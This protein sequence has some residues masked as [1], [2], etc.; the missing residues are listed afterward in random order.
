MFQNSDNLLG[1]S[2]GDERR[3]R[4]PLPQTRVTT[5]QRYS[6]IPP[7][8]R[9]REVESADD[10]DNTQRVPILQ[11]HVSRAWEHTSDGQLLFCIVLWHFGIPKLLFT[12]ELAQF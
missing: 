5:D 8:D 1:Y 9:D 11:Q 10:A 2:H 6:H 3:G 7:S 12:I 4:S